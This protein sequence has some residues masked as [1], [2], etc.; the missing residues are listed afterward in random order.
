MYCYIQNGQIPV[1]KKGKEI[2]IFRG[3][4]SSNGLSLVVKLKSQSVQQK[5]I[6]Y[7]AKDQVEGNSREMRIHK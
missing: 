5:S 3:M 2:H 6:K 7:S 4:I 1:N